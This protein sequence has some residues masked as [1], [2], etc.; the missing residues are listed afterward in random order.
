MYCHFMK[1][2]H[3]KTTC[4]EYD[5]NRERSRLKHCFKGA[6]LDR[7]LKLFNAFLT[8][9]FLAVDRLYNKLP[10]HEKEFVGLWIYMV[11]GQ[12]DFL[13]AQYVSKRESSVK[14][15]KMT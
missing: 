5:E 15:K 1:I 3:T 9:D 12:D 11:G 4:F 2:I 6:T 14:I 8:G 10:S 7:Q 13:T